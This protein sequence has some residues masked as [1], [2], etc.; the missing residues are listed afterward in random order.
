MKAKLR[1]NMQALL[2]TL[3]VLSAFV[4]DVN[5]QSSTITVSVDFGAGLIYFLVILFFGLNF[6][7]PVVR[8]LYVNYFSKW[9]E[10][11]SKEITKASKRFTERMSDASRRVTQSIRVDK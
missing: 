9:V 5:A 4:A 11:A 2:G 8:W 1:P 6:G 7:T 10:K 3:I